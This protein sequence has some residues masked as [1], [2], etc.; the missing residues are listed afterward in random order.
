MEA[1][2]QKSAGSV[3]LWTIFSL[4]FLGVLILVFI[5]LDTVK[6]KQMRAEPPPIYTEK[7]AEPQRNPDIQDNTNRD[8]VPAYLLDEVDKEAT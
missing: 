7:M 1:D 6:K 4:T 2:R 8:V 3:T 5:V